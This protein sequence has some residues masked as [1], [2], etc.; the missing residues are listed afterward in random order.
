MLVPAAQAAEHQLLA[1]DAAVNDQLGTS[2][3][4]DGDVAVVGAPHDNL[5]HGAAY[6]YVKTGG[7]WTEAAKLVASDGALAAL[8]G[9]RGESG[10]S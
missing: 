3:A 10:Q 4:I 5:D 1:S 8:R 2:V 7:V 9:R 6:V